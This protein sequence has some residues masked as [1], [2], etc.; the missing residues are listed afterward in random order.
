MVDVWSTVVVEVNGARR[1]DVFFGRGF[2]RLDVERGVAADRAVERVGL[3]PF[4]EDEVAFG[5]AG[6]SRS[7]K[8]SSSS[9]SSSSSRRGEGRFASR[10]GPRPRS[11]ASTFSSNA[12]TASYIHQL[13]ATEKEIRMMQVTD[14]QFV[15][16]DPLPPGRSPS[17]PSIPRSFFCF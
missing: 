13:K 12:L 14:T 4:L 1:V 9:S 16:S 15:F 3:R 7:P 17:I 6:G 2:G 10:S 11:S 5:G 8:S